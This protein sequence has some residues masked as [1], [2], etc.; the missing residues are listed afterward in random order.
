MLQGGTQRP[1]ILVLEPY[2]S[3]VVI[4]TEILPA[5]TV[6]PE[7]RSRLGAHV[8]QTGRTILSSIAVRLPKRLTALDGT[9]L[10]DALASATDYEMALFTGSSPAS[11]TRWPHNQWITG[12]IAD[13]S[14]MAQAA[15]VP[16]QIIDQAANELTDGIKAAA[17]LFAEVAHEYPGAIAKLG[18]ELRQENG[19][20]T[21]RMAAAILANAF[22]FHESLAGGP[23]DL[24]SVK[25]L[26]GLKGAGAL[27]KAGLLNEWTK[28]LK[29][30]Y[31][32]I[33]DIARRLLEHTPAPVSGEVVQTLRS[34]AGRR[35]GA[36]F[37]G[38]IGRATAV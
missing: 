6:E 9:H 12:G 28:I 14:I 36:W 19:E 18:E 34:P 16:P 23:G 29:V 2:V 26:D 3:P 17:G 7:A 33:F 21:L 11:A 4:E 38:F 27:S 20:Q 10:S 25:S 13:L 15:S 5:V 32:S 37:L 8:A 1:D 24:A 35:C 31:W 30:N 22:V